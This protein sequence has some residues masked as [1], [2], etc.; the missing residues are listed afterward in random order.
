MRDNVLPSANPTSSIRLDEGT[1]KVKMRKL[2]TSNYSTEVGIWLLLLPSMKRGVLLM[3]DKD[4]L[5]MGTGIGEMTT[6]G[7]G[8][9]GGNAGSST[10]SSSAMSGM[11]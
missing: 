4:V 5:N 1:K 10:A 6:D 9:R 7:T 8:D 3:F 2:I 11:T